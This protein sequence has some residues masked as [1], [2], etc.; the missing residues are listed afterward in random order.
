M[1]EAIVDNRTRDLFKEA[2]KNKNRYNFKP[3]NVDGCSGDGE[4]SI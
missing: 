1:A 3:S 2:R 4:I